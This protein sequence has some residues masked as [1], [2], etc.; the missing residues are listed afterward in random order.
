MVEITFS[1]PQM[2]EG[3]FWPSVL[4]ERRERPLGEIR[5][6]LDARYEKARESSQVR[7]AVDWD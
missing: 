2:R 4:Q 6:S 1:I 5:Y 3:G 7:D